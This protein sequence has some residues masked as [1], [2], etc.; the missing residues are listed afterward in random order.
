MKD[1]TV[2]TLTISHGTL[3]HWAAMIPAGLFGAGLSI[4]LFTKFWLIGIFGVMM[5]AL[6][7]CFTGIEFDPAKKLYREYYR[8]LFFKF[9]K[10]QS[11]EAYKFV[12]I[13]GVILRRNSDL[14]DKAAPVGSNDKQSVKIMLLNEQHNKKLLVLY[15]DKPNETNELLKQL[16]THLQLPFA[17]YS[18]PLSE[19]T[20][21]RR[22][23][24]GL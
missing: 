19:S 6:V 11:Y 3:M 9:G 20:L 23:S 14:P 8:I 17:K 12:S 1:S 22:K 7:L 21:R 24:R 18:P 5:L 4:Q 2:E 10:W 13:Q 16:T 15:S